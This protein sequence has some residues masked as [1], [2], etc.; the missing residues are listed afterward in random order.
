M[1][2]L[3][4]GTTTLTLPDDLD[5]QDEFSWSPVVQTAEPS[6][7]GAVLVQI[8][9]RQA[10]RPI[11]LVGDEQRAWVRGDVVTALDAW[12]HVAGQVLTLMLRGVSRSVIFRHHEAPAFDSREI[13]G[14]VPTLAAQQ[15]AITIK[16]MEI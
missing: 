11:T 3:S 16:L 8:G 13:F 15:H 7:T 2:T 4:D 1:T 14:E 9:T 6:V 10:G 12:S 5:W